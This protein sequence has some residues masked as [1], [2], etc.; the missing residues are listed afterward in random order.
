[1]RDEVLP[2]MIPGDDDDRIV[3]DGVVSAASA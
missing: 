2:T 1:M 3:L